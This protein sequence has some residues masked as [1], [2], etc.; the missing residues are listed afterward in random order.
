MAQSSFVCP[1]RVDLRTDVRTL[2]NWEQGARK[3]ECAR[4]A[5]DQSGQALSGDS[6]KARHNLVADYSLDQAVVVI[7]THNDLE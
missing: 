2:E 1:I 4:R 6:R 5:A 7:D 3:T